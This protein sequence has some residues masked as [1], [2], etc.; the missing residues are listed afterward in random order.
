[1]N[2]SET[3]RLLFIAL[4]VWGIFS[5]TPFAYCDTYETIAKV[6]QYEITVAYGDN[7]QIT[8]GTKTFRKGSKARFRIKPL[9]GYK[10][11]TITVDGV[12]IDLSTAEDLSKPYKYPFK[13]IIAAHTI[14]ATFKP[15]PTYD[16]TVMNGENGQITSSTTS[17]KEGANARFVILPS[18]GYRIDSIITDGEEV[19]LSG[20]R[21]LANPYRYVFKNITSPHTI[22]ATFKE[23]PKRN[24][25]FSFEND[26]EGWTANGLELNNI[27]WSVDRTQ[28]IA[29]DGINSVK[30]YLGDSIGDL[31][32]PSGAGIIWIERSFDVK[33]DKLYHV[34][35]RYDFGSADWGDLNLFRIITGAAQKSPQ[36]QDELIY[37][38]DS[39]NGD[40]SYVGYLWLEKSCGFDVRSSPDGKL[41]V[42]IG[43]DRTWEY[44]RTYYLD[45]VQVKFTK[46]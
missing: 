39:G 28:E 11:E 32:G 27:I 7:G 42:Y 38:G 34:N 8:P 15:I 14:S 46:Q 17:F 37:Q 16:V 40:E 6:K 2:N 21:N 9:E 23:L 4:I 36:S 26:M 22:S 33:P 12:N 43:V 41:Y 44:D 13:N 25:S 1:M 35:V 20:V 24:Y 5:V 18:N 45:N 30:L 29:S 3:N 10:I 31:G 19:D